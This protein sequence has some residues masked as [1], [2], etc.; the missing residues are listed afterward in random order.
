MI[1]FY[2][3]NTYEMRSFINNGITFPLH[4]HQQLE[5]IYILKG[6][7]NVT[8]SGLTETLYE[9]DIAV[10]FPDCI[11]GFE[12]KKEGSQSQIVICDIRHTG[13]FMNKL[14]NYY[15]T[16][17]FLRRISLS[18]NIPYAMNELSL[19]YQ[20]D[21]NFAACTSFIQLILAR[22]FPLLELEAKQDKF[23]TD[24]A[25][26]IANY[27]NNNYKK[28]I[29]LDNL[30]SYLGLSKYHVSH[31]FSKTFKMSFPKYLNS[32]R[33]N[34]AMAR[35]ETTRDSFLDICLEVGFNSQRT[36]NR[37]FNEIYHMTPGEYRKSLGQSTQL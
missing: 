29:T 36:F 19:E 16:N 2:E 8:I 13:I 4:L 22:L 21:F 20:G 10:I 31:I 23:S 11:H 12:S 25:S 35:I 30:A 34:H 6:E 15:P 17:P 37:I 28:P 32:I 1:P 33:L 9:G 14:V 24:Y 5:L 7:Q 26:Q 3:S 18:N 27:I